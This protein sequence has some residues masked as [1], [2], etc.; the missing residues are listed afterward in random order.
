MTS[1]ETSTHHELSLEPI[2]NQGNS[3]GQLKSHPNTRTTADRRVVPER[4]Q[5]LR[6]EG[7]RRSGKIR[8][9]QSS[10]DGTITR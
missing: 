9:P 1:N 3:T 2:D 4:R 8:R 7:E 10:W 5:V 6:F